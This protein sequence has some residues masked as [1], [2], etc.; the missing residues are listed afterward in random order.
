MTP[1]DHLKTW[2]FNRRLIRYAPG[3]FAIFALFNFLF[4]AGA[5]VPGLVVQAIFD[6][7]TGRADVAL[8]IPA[9]IA[10]F[11]AIEVARFAGSF[12]QVWGDVTFRLT[13][14][15]LL[16][17]NMLAAILDR[18]GALSL[19]IASGSAVN[20]FRDD[21]D[22][23]SDFPTWFP[24]EV[25]N[26]LG[27]VIALVL[28]ARINLT[29]TVYA[30]LP[31]AVSLIVG[32]WG[33]DQLRQLM[34]LEDAATDRVTGFLA[35]A[36]AAVQTVKLAGA[37]PAMATHFTAL[38]HDRQTYAVRYRLVYQAINS[39]TW[40]GVAVGMGIV[41]LLAAHAMA[42]HSFTVGDFALFVYLLQ[43]TNETATDF[44]NFLGDWI[45]QTVSIVRMEELVR[46]GPSQRVLEFHPVHA[47]E[48]A[49]PSFG[50]DSSGSDSS[51]PDES[52]RGEP[53]RSLQV[54]D[55]RYLYPGGGG[56]RGADFD[57]PAG[58]LTVITGRVG[59]GKSTL[60]RALLG[61][62][63][64]QGGEIRWNGRPVTNPADHFRPP[65]AAYVPQ[66]PHL[67]SESLR[68]NILMGWSVPEADVQ[69]AIWQA[70]LED[71]TSHLSTG[72][73]TLVG[74]RGVRL[75]GGQ[76][77]RAA[78]ARAFVRRPDLLVVDD[79]S[80]A[81]DVE[82]ERA[83]WERLAARQDM[84]VLAVSHRREA[85][86][87]ADRVIVLRDGEIVASGPLAELLTTSEELRH[88]WQRES[89]R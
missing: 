63:P 17:R 88:L 34:A 82:T 42:A 9:L 1:P 51:G 59:A 79:L 52:A 80:S 28:M 53:L 60:L 43:F 39:T 37:G 35:E 74:P 50:P 49:P 45:N 87:R 16:R 68:H 13:T 47:D 81:L 36:F 75:S 6:R 22:E 5:F 32:R 69:E 26:W 14:G 38:N 3:P 58:T 8:G 48:S 85:L 40:L 57:L 27:T 41:L 23:T 4:T 66:V 2:P 70:V 67:C 20:R 54:R 12:G 24:G 15:A 78:A 19:P 73:D 30:F 18:P 7:L 31:M 86:T 21:V 10:L 83:L 71:D 33:W 72:L 77:Q 55:L 84:T 11:V 89:S 62:L 64:A 44:G 25:G 65:R 61:Q 76:I 46:P 56:I 29:I